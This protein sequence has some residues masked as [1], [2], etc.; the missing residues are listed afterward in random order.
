MLGA[1]ALDCWSGLHTDVTRERGCSV[2][3]WKVSTFM[4][5]FKFWMLLLYPWDLMVRSR[6][7]KLYKWATSSCCTRPTRFKTTQSGVIC[8]LNKHFDI[9][10]MSTVHLIFRRVVAWGML[11]GDLIEGKL[12]FL[13]LD[14]IL[15]ATAIFML[16]CLEVLWHSRIF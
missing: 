7:D 10:K 13:P 6:W 11:N 4:K 1:L 3:F 5:L 15:V 8:A 2:V 9:T 14:L 12:H 16:L